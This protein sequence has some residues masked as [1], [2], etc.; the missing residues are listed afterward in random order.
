M[1]K[2]VPGWA[3]DYPL[4]EITCDPGQRIEV[5]EIGYVM[6]NA[7]YIF[8]RLFGRQVDQIAHRPATPLPEHRIIKR[9]THLV[10]GDAY[11]FTAKNNISTENFM[12][13]FFVLDIKPAA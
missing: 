6:W 5:L 12:Q 2:W 7:G 10:E 13:L 8:G 11:R 9:G 1:E 3:V 4:G